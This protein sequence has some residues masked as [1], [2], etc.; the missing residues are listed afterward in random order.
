MRYVQRD[1]TGQLIGHFAN[2][3]PYAKELVADDHPDILAWQAAR[4]YRQHPSVHIR[5]EATLARSPFAR[6]LTRVVAR[7]L[8]LTEAELIQQV[9]DAAG[10][11]NLARDA[12]DQLFA[13]EK[14]ES[15]KAV[16]GA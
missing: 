11:Q 7:A 9:K 6:G 3:Q 12:M 13:V 16:G 14:E 5:V 4:D 10:E 1:E 2:E 15:A 8:S